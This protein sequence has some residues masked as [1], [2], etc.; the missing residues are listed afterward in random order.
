MPRAS[1]YVAAVE[2][3]PEESERR[4]VA[5][6]A[7]VLFVPSRILRRVLKR[8]RRIP[9][10]GLDV[11][12]ASSYV[13]ARDA[14]LAFAT[15]QELGCTRAHLSDSVILL[16][17]PAEDGAKAPRGTLVRLWRSAFHARIHQALEA[18]VAS[19]ALSPSVVRARVHRVG[20]T[21]FDEIRHVLR[22]DA[23]LL[24]P[25]DATSVYVEFVATYL[26]LLQFDPDHLARTF[27]AL[28]D[29][30]GLGELIA[31]DLDVPLL[32]AGCRPEG[33]PR[34]EELATRAHVG[35]EDARHGPPPPRKLEP[36]PLPWRTMADEPPE[37]TRRAEAAEKRGN[38]VRAMLIRAPLR[39]RGEAGARKNLVTLAQ[40]LASALDWPDAPVDAWAS[41]LFPLLTSAGARSLPWNAEGR[42]L[43][44]L[45]RACL[46]HEHEIFT[47]SVA[48]WAL[49]LGK[50]PIRRALPAQREVRVAKHVMSALQRVEDVR[51]EDAARHEVRALLVEMEARAEHNTRRALRPRLKAALAEVGL[52]ATNVPEQVSEHKLVEELIDHVVLA[53]FLSLGQ[54]RDAIARNHIKLRSLRVR[55]LVSGDALLEIDR[56]LTHTLD[57]VYRPAE[58]YVR[59]LQKLSSITFGTVPG[60][61]L[62]LYL[63]L[64]IVCAYVVLEGLQHVV[65]PLVAKLPGVGEPELVGGPS[66]AVT[67]AVL[68]ALIHSSTARFLAKR[69]L[70]LLGR[71]L[72]FVFV[73]APGFLW[74]LSPVQ[75]FVQSRPVQLT[76]RF[77]L[78]PLALAAVGYAAVHAFPIEQWIAG[79]GAAVVFIV[80]N[81]VLNSRVGAMAEEA[82]T[83]WAVR[84]WGQLHRRILPGLFALIAAFFRRML[85]LMDRTFYAVDELLRF[86]QGDGRVSFYAKGGLGLLWFVV[87]YLVRL[88]VNLLVEPEINPI[89]HFPV[90]TVAAKLMIPISP[91]LH[92]A[93]RVPLTR[94]LGGFIGETIAVSTV[95]VLPGFF[96]FLVWELKE[97]WKLYEQNRARELLPVVIGHHG[98]TMIALMRPG[99]HSGT[100]PKI[101]A[102]LRHASQKGK[103]ALHQQHEALAHVRDALRR[104]LERELVGLLDQAERW[105]GGHLEVGAITMASNRIRIALSCPSMGEAP[106]EVSFEEQ[107]GWLLGS[108]TRSGFLDALDDEQ[109]IVFEN[110][111]AGLYKVAGVDLVRE[112]VTAC[113]GSTPYDIMD[114]GLLLWPEGSWTTEVVYDLDG[115]GK[116]RPRRRTGDAPAPTLE[117]RDLL[118]RNV[119]LL[120]ADWV[121]AWAAGSTA[122][123]VSGASLLP[124]RAI[125]KL[126]A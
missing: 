26:E 102:R 78:K 85:E 123:L 8:H 83:D 9:G 23:L 16:P 115:R 36:Q 60:R 18:R 28:A 114:E 43:Y 21:E 12:H 20:Q 25:H 95:F 34:A 112:R 2:P 69:L 101:Y 49:S 82:A 72:R 91:H 117:A 62:V 96:G 116:L 81:V 45:L 31:L 53:R 50:R 113:L 55:E 92:H 111:L 76:V 58:I 44:D 38:L 10:V 67:A 40:R 70:K 99:L 79:T 110:A 63:L 13:V 97:N 93:M 27:P 74:N 14:L 125:G 103:D 7:G 90:V 4:V 121:A 107:S 22:Q 94:L 108:V 119:P 64:P 46:D 42:L 1:W 52:V 11:P 126:N 66:I 73:R 30:Q 47:V 41:V 57:G 15:E 61:L 5:T 17:H 29:P 75:A 35:T 6:G 84:T 104:F 39:T 56:I 33:T 124:P 59:A 71:A 98:E 122:R 65:G 80:A 19:G 105:H 87:T 77:L 89:K 37:V 109:R 32:L 24:P 106:A 3:S 54:L 88:Y 118:Y 120:W 48:E 51:L 68:F 86:R 100:I